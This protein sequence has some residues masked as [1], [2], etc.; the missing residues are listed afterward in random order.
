MISF[1]SFT[2]IIPQHKYLL[3]FFCEK[4]RIALISVFKKNSKNILFKQRQNKRQNYKILC[5]N[6]KEMQLRFPEAPMRKNYEQFKLCFIEHR[7]KHI[8]YSTSVGYFVQRVFLIYKLKLE[9]LVYT[10]SRRI[11]IYVYT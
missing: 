4:K 11:C 1:E 10:L 7:L 3:I 9:H 2:I 8:I 5:K 6:S